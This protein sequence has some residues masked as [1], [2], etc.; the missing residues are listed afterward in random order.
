MLIEQK[1][2]FNKTSFA[3][4]E[5]SNKYSN[6]KPNKYSTEKSNSIRNG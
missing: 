1:D 3:G 2:K 6:E 5:A 4:S